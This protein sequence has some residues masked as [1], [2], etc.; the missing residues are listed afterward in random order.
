MSRVEASGICWHVLPDGVEAEAL[1][2]RCSGIRAILMSIL[3]GS[4]GDVVVE[5][6]GDE[7]Q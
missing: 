1:L 5:R 4:C 3:N 6:K 7:D 2:A